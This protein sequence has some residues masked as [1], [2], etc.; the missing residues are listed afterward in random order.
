[1]VPV[2][3]YPPLM[4]AWLATAPPTVTV[5]GLAVA[6]TVG[7]TLRGAPVTCTVLLAQE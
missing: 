5:E 2:G 3:W 6:A 1:M 7:F 4:V